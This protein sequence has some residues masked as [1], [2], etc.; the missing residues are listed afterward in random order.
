MAEYS[1]NAMDNTK[2]F[3]ERAREIVEQEIDRARSLDTKA[4]AVIAASVALTAASAAFVLRLGDQSA[5]TGAKVLW[6]VEIGIAL[7]ALLIAGALAVW[8]LAPMVVRSQVAFHELTSWVTL[9]VLEQAPTTNEGTLLNASLLSI[10]VSRNANKAKS[11]R[12]R[13]SSI[14]LGAGLAAIVALTISVAISSTDSAA[15]TG[16]EIDGRSTGTA[17][18]STG[19]RAGAGAGRFDLPDAGHGHGAARG[20]GRGGA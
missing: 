4:G 19:K 3:A 11:E 13:Y 12:L 2:L 14:A 20:L 10:G 16:G 15:Q 17:R 1:E 6:T 8:A 7:I 5:G 18:E 9:P